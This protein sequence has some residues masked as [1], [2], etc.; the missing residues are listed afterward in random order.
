MADGREQKGGSAARVA[1]AGR[2]QVC[3]MLR[4]MAAGWAAGGTA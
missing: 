3:S 1:V 2:G 4:G